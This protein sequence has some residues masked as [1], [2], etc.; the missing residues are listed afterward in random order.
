MTQNHQ[1]IKA[2]PV[3]KTNNRRLNLEFYCQTLGMKNLL[4]EGPGVSLGDQT[5]SEKL[6]IEESPGARSRKVVGPK[7]LAQITIKV[8]EPKEIEALLGQ[9]HPVLQVYQGEKGYAF[10]TVSP[11]GDTFLVHAED[12]SQTLRALEKTPVFETQTEF[13]GLTQFYIEKVILNVPN[14]SV[15]Q[16]Y[17]QPFGD[18]LPIEFKEEEGQ[19][20]LA[21]NAATWDLSM[22]KFSLERFDVDQLAELLEGRDLF[23]PKSKKFLLATDD[24]QIDLWFEQ[25]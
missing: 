14:K 1:T 12:D 17:Y 4:E 10:K 25:A 23:V 13:T 8:E 16:T 18:T 11:E 15:A 5:K 2:V 19:D 21:K 20:L 3:L 24:S 9:A 6:V 7:K 22:I